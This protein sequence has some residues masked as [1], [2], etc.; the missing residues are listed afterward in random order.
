MIPNMINKWKKPVPNF[1]ADLARGRIGELGFL[2][3]TKGTV[4][5]TDGRTGDFVLTGTKIKL[6]VKSDYYDPSKTS[7]FFIEKYRSGNKPGGVW[8]AQEHGCKYFLYCFVKTGTI[9]AFNTKKLCERL[10]LLH[11]SKNLTLTSVNNPGYTTRGLKVHRDLVT[12]LMLNLSDIGVTFD[13]K[14]YLWYINYNK[15]QP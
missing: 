4:E 7:N 12:D 15:A 9:Y 3:A 2:H 10:D 8:Q 14:E 11:D 13:S 6:E 5:P 1:Q